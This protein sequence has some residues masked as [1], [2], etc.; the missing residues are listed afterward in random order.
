MAN[1]RVLIVDDTEHVRQDL[2]TFLTLTGGIE[3]I[4]EA[5]NGLEAVQLAETLCPQ[6]VLMDLEMPVMDGYE[7]T[8][9]IKALQPSCRVVALTV[10]GEQTEQKK[11]LAAG[12]DAFVIKGSPMET[13]MKAICSPPILGQMPAGEKDERYP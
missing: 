1:I 4:G 8:R 12:M 11:A 3:I 10:H 7:A 2:S 5:D 6:V 13:L 9:Q